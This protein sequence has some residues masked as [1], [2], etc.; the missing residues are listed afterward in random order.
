MIKKSIF[1]AALFLLAYT[2]FL[3]LK[4][5]ISSSQS[6]LQ[7]NKTKAERYLFDIENVDEKSVIIGSSLSTFL[8][9]DS[10]PSFY[11]LAFGGQTLF[12]GIHII[13]RGQI[14]P[15]AVYIETNIL[16]R[17]PNA[18]FVASLEKP[19]SYFLKSKLS[20]FRSDKLPL[21]VFVGYISVL[22]NKIE[23]I[24][25]TSTP[26]D[27]IPKDEINSVENTVKIEVVTESENAENRVFSK[28]LFL[29]EKSLEGAVDTVFL[30][31]QL[32]TLKSFVNYLQRN[33]VAVFF[34]EMPINKQLENLHEPSL[35]RRAMRE[36]FP[37]KQYVYLATDTAAYKTTDG[38]HLKHDEALRFTSFFKK[39]VRY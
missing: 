10:L 25:K 2:V 16:L 17:R 6:Q 26:P 34:F 19:I 22:K 13:K 28:M 36:K 8:N 39:Q 30:Q 38:L 20:L 14:L 31:E 35:L 7:Q 24:F 5:S 37:E 18:D 33:K 21:S 27:T 1:Y 23:S 15:K 11:N 3:T 9:N 12:E 4:P 29:K 32:D